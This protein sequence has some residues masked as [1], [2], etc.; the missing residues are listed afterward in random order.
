MCPERQG[1]IASPTAGVKNDDAE[2]RRRTSDV[3]RKKA[4]L[5]KFEH[6]DRRRR[7]RGVQGTAELEG[8]RE[9]K[10]QLY[11]RGECRYRVADSARQSS[12][13]GE[14]A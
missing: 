8:E 1:T 3:R 4:V 13:K 5:T 7:S 12:S 6:N 11:R 9:W 2:S 14:E 10:R